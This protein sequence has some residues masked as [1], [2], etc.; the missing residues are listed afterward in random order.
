MPF[1]VAPFNG[2]PLR[3]TPSELSATTGLSSSRPIGVGV[4]TGRSSLVAPSVGRLATGLAPGF[5]VEYRLAA[6]SASTTCSTSAFCRSW[7][8]WATHNWPNVQVLLDSQ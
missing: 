6:S 5:G 1:E 8:L 4:T 3:I 2:S 7:I